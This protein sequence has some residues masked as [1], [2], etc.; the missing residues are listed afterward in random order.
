M[1]RGWFDLSV[2]TAGTPSLLASMAKARAV[3]A[4]LRAEGASLQPSTHSEWDTASA[5]DLTQTV[6]TVPSSCGTMVKLRG[7]PDSMCHLTVRS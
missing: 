6:Q 7:S 5:C 3:T 2:C 4:A 1:L